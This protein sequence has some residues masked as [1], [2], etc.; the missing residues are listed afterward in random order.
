M[1]ESTPRGKKLTFDHAVPSSFGVPPSLGSEASVYASAFAAE[2]AVPNI[3][4]MPS[5]P[6]DIV[7][8]FIF[9]FEPDVPPKFD[10]PS[11]LGSEACAY[12]P[13][14]A[15]EETVSIPAPVPSLSGN[16]VESF[17]FPPPTENWMFAWDHS[18]PTSNG[19]AA[20]QNSNP[21]HLPVS[22][23]LDRYPAM[24]PPSGSLSRAITSSERRLSVRAPLVNSD[25]DQGPHSRPAQ[26]TAASHATSYSKP[27]DERP[28][29]HEYHAS[30]EAVESA[31]RPKYTRRSQYL[32]NTDNAFRTHAFSDLPFYQKEG[33]S[34][35]DERIFGRRA[36]R[37]L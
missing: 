15:A 20:A 6:G 11:S 1:F 29:N 14:F 26:A 8:P 31:R 18:Q 32:N 25:F 23:D 22:S 17:A 27:Q 4:R 33:S 9:N 12:V 30:Y 21:G 5:L 24:L 10:I 34:S 7:R 13:V 16:I 3:A 28:E 35:E 37:T 2:E 19:F 36:Q